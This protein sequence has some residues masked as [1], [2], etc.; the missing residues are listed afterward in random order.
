MAI[1][2]AVPPAD[3]LDRTFAISRKFVVLTLAT[4]ELYEGERIFSSRFVLGT[5][6][7]TPLD[8]NEIQIDLTGFML[9]LRWEK[10]SF[11]C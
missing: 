7:S 2:A 9:L 11:P 6:S 10:P 5:I 4:T 3:V 1:L 8:R